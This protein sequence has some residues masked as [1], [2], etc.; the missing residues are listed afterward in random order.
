MTR[1]PN[2][3][4][5]AVGLDRGLGAPSCPMSP[6]AWGW[7]LALLG[8]TALL[9]FY[10]LDGGARFEPIDTWVS[11]TAREMLAEGDWLTPRFAGETRMQKS[12]GPYWAVM[13]TSIALDRPI[14]EL[15]ARVPNAFAA[16]G[17]VLVV[18]WLT[19]R[20]AGDRAAIFAG[21]AMASSSFLLYW[22]HRGASDLGL[23]FFTTLSLAALWVG[24]ESER[25]GVKRTLLTMLAYFAAGLGMLYKMPMPLVVCGLPVVVYLLYRADWAQLRWISRLFVFLLLL[26]AS[27]AAGYFVAPQLEAP[28]NMVANAAHLPNTAW[29]GAAVGL[30]AACGFI[31]LMLNPWFWRNSLIGHGAG[32]LL[33]FAPWLP[34]AIAVALNEPAALDKWRVEFLDRYTGDLPNVEGQDDP[35]FLL[36]YLTMPL[37]YCLPYSLSLPM[38]L[39]RG[40]RRD[41]RV[42]RPGMMFMV[43]WWSSLLL[44]FTSSTGKE[45]RYFLPALPPLFVLLGVELSVFFDSFIER[46]KAWLGGIAVCVGVLAGGPAAVWTLHRYWQPVVGEPSGFAWQDVWP[47]VVVVLSILCSG[48]LL[49]TWLYLARRRSMSFGMLV[50]TMFGLWLWAWPQVMPIFLSQTEFVD[51]SRQM[52]ERFNP[53]MRQDLRWIGSQDPRIIWNSGI[54]VPR[55]IDQLDLLER[56]GG[57]R[58]L[59]RETQLY[60]E[61]MLRRLRADERVL[62]VSD[63]NSYMS[64]MALAPPALAERGE[65][66]P[67]V[68]LWMA[69]T[70]GRLDRYYVIFGN[71]PRP[72]DWPEPVLPFKNYERALQRIRENPPPQVRGLL[73]NPPTA[74]TQPE[75]QR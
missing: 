20:V 7:L 59:R 9:C 61:E 69:P 27:G 14:D 44:F 73:E 38:A 24:H 31:L 60:V 25:P 30:G 55:L 42:S 51:L 15:T 70:T 12:P 35:R 3:A 48:I 74:A 11:Q 45:W 50:G 16:L 57:E 39:W 46:R 13:T 8:W 19:R 6:A 10:D 36:M 33:F 54:A 66:M 47:P 17:L 71:Q 4:P 43:L 65:S 28:L 53:A 72:D 2:P 62:F 68:H 5:A 26:G 21:F 58:S 34:W 18:F 56:Q 52:R 75:T 29:A 63:I 1:G 23:T 40:V 32:V 64:L 67:P 41:V 22:S 49:S 37:V